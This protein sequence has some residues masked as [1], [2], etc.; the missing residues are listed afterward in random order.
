MRDSKIDIYERLYVMNREGRVVNA[1]FSG[2]SEQDILDSN[3]SWSY[4]PDRFSASWS[5]EPR[6]G[7]FLAAINCSRSMCL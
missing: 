6:N 3:I 1:S 2:I 7:H 5:E 4:N